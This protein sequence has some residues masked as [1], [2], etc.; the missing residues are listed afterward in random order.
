MND[1]IVEVVDDGQKTIE[2]FEVTDDKM[3]YEKLR[4][5]ELEMEKNPKCYSID[6]MDKEIEKILQ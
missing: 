2:E 1:K 3:I 4:E 6:E 5:A